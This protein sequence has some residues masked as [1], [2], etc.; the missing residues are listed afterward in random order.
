MATKK[1]QIIDGKIFQS[2]T[3]THAVLSASNWVGDGPYTQTIILDNI[4]INNKVDIQADINTIVAMNGYCLCAC[5]D[6]GVV[7]VYAIGEKPEVDLNI[8]IVITAVKKPA[9]D[10]VIW[11]NTLR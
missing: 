5:N 6:N 1:I 4:A 10:D 8:Q 7:T 2:G 11:G 9:P 3:M